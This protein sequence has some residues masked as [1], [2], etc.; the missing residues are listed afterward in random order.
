M[1]RYCNH[2]CPLLICQHSSLSS[3]N[4]YW[5]KRANCKNSPFYF[6][7][8]ARIGD[9]ASGLLQYPHTSPSLHF[10]C[11]F[12]TSLCKS[13][14]WKQEIMHPHFSIYIQQKPPNCHPALPWYRSLSG[15]SCVDHFPTSVRV[16]S[17]LSNLYS[18]SKAFNSLFLPINIFAPPF[19][20]YYHN[21]H[22]RFSQLCFS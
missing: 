22:L 2:I 17:N 18:L 13:G 1:Y 20:P 11:L 15:L 6:P 5:N 3:A 12:H 14:L 19:L 7:I 9:F 8:L 21:T 4:L 10:L 16:T